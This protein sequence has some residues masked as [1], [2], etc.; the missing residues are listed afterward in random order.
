MVSFCQSPYLN[1]TCKNKMDVVFHLWVLCGSRMRE[2]MAH[3][4]V[5]PLWNDLFSGLMAVSWH[6]ACSS[7]GPTRL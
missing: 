7:H 3:G 5:C 6:V 4:I 1:S 2:L